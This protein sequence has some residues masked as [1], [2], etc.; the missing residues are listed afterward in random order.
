MCNTEMGDTLDETMIQLISSN[1]QPVSFPEALQP[2]CDICPDLITWQKLALN[3]AVSVVPQLKIQISEDMAAAIYIYTSEWPNREDSLYFK[4][5][6]VLRNPNRENL[7]KP[8][9]KFIQ[10][11]MA[12]L[13]R[14]TPLPKQN[15]WR[16]VT[17]NIGQSYQKNARVTWRCF[18]SCSLNVE[19]VKAFLGANAKTLFL[20]S[21]CTAYEISELSAFPGEREVLL[22]FG[23]T[24]QVVNVATIDNVTIVE[25]HEIPN[26]TDVVQ[27]ETRMS[28]PPTPK[29]VETENKSPTPPHKLPPLADK[30][31]IEWEPQ[32]IANWLQTLRLSADYTESVLKKG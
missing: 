26:V 18:S 2:L 19:A 6:A 5:N 29:P 31:F 30:P 11:L 16:G 23:I 21:N 4:L 15:L 32:L 13:K 7:M 8:Y 20:I 3:H 28:V 14:L 24:L 12:G 22:P 1:T 27:S 10:L 25:L 17:G 9:F